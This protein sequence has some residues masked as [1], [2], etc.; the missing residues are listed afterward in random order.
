MPRKSVD[1]KLWIDE[2]PKPKKKLE[3]PLDKRR[4]SSK[5]ADNYEESLIK[6]LFEE[7][8]KKIEEDIE[9]LMNIEQ[10][11]IWVHHR[12][13]DE[14]WDV[15]ITETIEYFDPEL[16]Y[17][18]TGYRPITMEQ[19]L[20]FDPTPFREVASIFDNNGKYTN[21]PNGSVPNK[22]FWDREMDRIVNG[23][24]VGKYRITGDHYYFLNYY[25]MQ[26]IVEDAIAGTG[27][28]YAF[29]TFLAKQYEWFHY[30]E[31]SEKLALNV[32]ALKGRGVNILPS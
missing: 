27:R 21:F 23:Y 6:Q 30:V 14:E 32:G 12:R 9:H 16:S 10:N 15:P 29:P 7:K 5:F 1:P 11:T 31:M 25:R 4:K 28:E 8:Q 24:T 17:E 3:T 22:K 26:T 20:D 19:G 2:K 18:L 13:K